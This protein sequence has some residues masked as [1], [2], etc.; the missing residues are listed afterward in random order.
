MN[1]LSWLT[2]FVDPKVAAVAVAVIEWMKGWLPGDWAKGTR[3]RMLAL[4]VVAGCYIGMWAAEASAEIK[5]VGVRLVAIVVT[6]ALSKVGYEAVK[7]V[8]TNSPPMADDETPVPVVVVDPQPAQSEPA[9]PSA[10][11]PV[12]GVA[13]VSQGGTTSGQDRQ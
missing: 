12:H 4:I 6:Y 9:V 1:D 2:Q 11:S 3:V 8:G 10:V 5:H 13:D 7:N